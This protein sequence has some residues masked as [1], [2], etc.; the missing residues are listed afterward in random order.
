MGAHLKKRAKTWASHSLL[1]KKKQVKKKSLHRLDNLEEQYEK[2][3]KKNGG[4][5]NRRVSKMFRE[6]AVGKAKKAKTSTRHA[7]WKQAHAKRKHLKKP[8]HSLLQKAVH[9]KRNQRPSAR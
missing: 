6:L 5:K 3:V 7:Q 1:Q 9:K 8:A 2:A 4:K